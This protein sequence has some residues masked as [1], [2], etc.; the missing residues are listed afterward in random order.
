M[1]TCSFYLG[2]PENSQQNGA[3]PEQPEVDELQYLKP[4]GTQ[5]F[6]LF[7]L[8]VRADDFEPADAGSEAACPAEPLK[9][10]VA[11]YKA[12]STI[13]VDTRHFELEKLTVGWKPKEFFSSSNSNRFHSKRAKKAASW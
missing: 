10:A 4:L 8:D 5:N 6:F 13:M 9:R 2:Y 1:D 7:R 11:I 12:S 3:P